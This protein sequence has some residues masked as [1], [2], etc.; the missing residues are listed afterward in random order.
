[1]CFVTK[2]TKTQ[3]QQ[4]NKIQHKNLCWSRELNLGPLSSKA[5][6]LPLCQN[7]NK[8]AEFSG[9]HFSTNS[10]FWYYFNMH[11]LLYLAV[12]H[13]YGSMF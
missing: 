6:V 13:I 8:K 2:K 11:G 10:I 5:D 1:M 7:V 12:P 3:Q 4:T 9:Q